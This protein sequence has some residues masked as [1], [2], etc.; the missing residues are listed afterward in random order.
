[1]KKILNL[2]LVH[3]NSINKQ[4]NILELLNKYHFC[5]QNNYLHYYH[6]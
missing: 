4:K 3:I 5:Y 2:S 6:T 1:M